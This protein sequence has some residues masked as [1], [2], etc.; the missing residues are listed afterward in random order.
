LNLDL[1]DLEELQEREEEIRARYEEIVRIQNS[2]NSNK[3]EEKKEKLK[4]EK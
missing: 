2:L 1:L 4:S 3:N